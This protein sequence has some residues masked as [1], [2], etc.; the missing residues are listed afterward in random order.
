MSCI[1]PGNSNWD[2]NQLR[3]LGPC[4]LV[5]PPEHVWL[6]CSSQWPGSIRLLDFIAHSQD[7]QPK[8][9][10]CFQRPAEHQ[11]ISDSLSP[12]LSFTPV[13]PLPQQYVA[14]AYTIF[15]AI[16][17]FPICCQWNGWAIANYSILLSIQIF[18]NGFIWLCI[19][20]F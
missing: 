8:C 16:P 14:F 9:S 2:G 7:R 6:L 5:W 10:E 20:T 15:I 19:I 1:F 12:L 11:L 17:D 18:F 4:S 3:G 13:S